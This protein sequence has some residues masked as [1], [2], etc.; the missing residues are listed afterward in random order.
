MFIYGPVIN[1]SLYKKDIPRCSL[2]A[3]NFFLHHFHAPSFAALFCIQNHQIGRSSN[4]KVIKNI[5]KPVLLMY[6]TESM[7]IWCKQYWGMHNVLKIG[8]CLIMWWNEVAHS[9]F[10]QCNHYLR[11]QMTEKK[12]HLK[13]V[14]HSICNSFSINTLRSQFQPHWICCLYFTT[15]P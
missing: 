12:T 8:V 11:K 13:R 6:Q 2:R 1:S 5:S 7:M 10:P 9:I 15:V 4:F 3:D 14:F